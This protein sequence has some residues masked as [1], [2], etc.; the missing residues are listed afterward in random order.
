[1][2]CTQHSHPRVLPYIVRTLTRHQSWLLTG[3]LPELERL[4][5]YIRAK[6]RRHSFSLGTSR[7]TSGRLLLIKDTHSAFL[8]LS[9]GIIRHAEHFVDPALAFAQGWNNVYSN[10]VSIPGE[11]VATAVLFQFWL[12][13]NNAIWI[14]VFAAL[15]VVT[16]LFMVRLYGELEFGFSMLKILLIVMVNIMVSYSGVDP[17]LYSIDAKWCI[18]E[19]A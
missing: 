15:C 18:R 8:P 4:Y 13:V 7:E 6:V 11:L 5:V 3:G 9:G 17:I 19:S 12:S 14:S 1:M 16:N 2:P 10:V